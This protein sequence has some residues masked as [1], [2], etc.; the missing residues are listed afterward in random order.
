M[1]FPNIFVVFIN[2]FF[3]FFKIVTTENCSIY[4]RDK[5]FQSCYSDLNLTNILLTI[6]IQ[7]EISINSN[8][9]NYS[10]E[11]NVLLTNNITLLSI[12][13]N[14]SLIFL[15]SSC[16][17]LNDS[18]I[19]LSIINMTVVFTENEFS[20]SKFYFFICNHTTLILKVKKYY[21]LYIFDFIELHYSN[22]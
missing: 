14:N 15:G 4:Q 19:T 8:N 16:I 7:T 2:I 1:N 3:S 17:I 5:Y 13:T 20:D 18:Y 9:G 11:S 22:L 12:G 10:I 21:S 6:V